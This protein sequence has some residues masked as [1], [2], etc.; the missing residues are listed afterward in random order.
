MI[1]VWLIWLTRNRVGIILRIRQGHIIRAD[2]AN[3]SGR[4]SFDIFVLLPSITPFLC[5]ISVGPILLL[6]L[7]S[8][9]LVAFALST[10]LMSD[11]LKCQR[12]SAYFFILFFSV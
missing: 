2:F 7:G 3:M 1:T 11:R 4:A 12:V 8:T 6:K 10:I 9:Y 5:I